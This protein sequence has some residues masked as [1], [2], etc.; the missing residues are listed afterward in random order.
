L[1]EGRCTHDHPPRFG[2]LAQVHVQQQVHARQC[3]LHHIRIPAVTVARPGSLPVTV[4]RVAGLR[5]SPGSPRLTGQRLGWWIVRP[6][7]DRNRG[8]REVTR[9]GSYA[10]GSTW[11]VTA[12]GPEITRTTSS[13]AVTTPSPPRA[14]WLRRVPTRGWQGGPR[15]APPRAS[16]P[17]R[18]A[19]SAGGIPRRCVPRPPQVTPGGT[20]LR[21]PR[22][23][24]WPRPTAGRRP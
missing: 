17:P 16:P 6:G 18:A 1:G 8:E 9:E 4:R 2:P 3:G 11:G 7:G 5:G 21:Y 24:S 15:S 23:S 13:A 22:P 10:E 14:R 12:V 20:T 19:E